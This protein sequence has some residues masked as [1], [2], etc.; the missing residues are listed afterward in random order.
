MASE[1]RKLAN[2]FRRSWVSAEECV[3]FLDGVRAR[4]QNALV[5]G[6]TIG[7][8]DP[9]WRPDQGPMQFADLVTLTRSD[10]EGDEA[11]LQARALGISLSCA[12]LGELLATVFNDDRRAA[13]VF[14][15]TPE[16]V[17]SV[18]H[19]KQAPLVILR[20]A[21]CHPGYLPAPVNEF[22]HVD[23]LIAALGDEQSALRREL[24]RNR[25]ALT[26]MVLARW[27]L[28]RVDDL[29]RFEIGRALIAELRGRGIGVSLEQ[30][31]RIEGRAVDHD[32]PGDMIRR[33]HTAKSALELLGG[34]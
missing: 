5:A 13:S 2:T 17:D 24:S 31:R 19:E 33:L 30:A 9:A 6:R 23:N 29:G 8:S 3:Q 7:P 27:A 14:E 20:N 34:G 1:S 11:G 4:R 22:S 25:F 28:R 18:R 15:V 12:L 16:S 10:V 21:I 32:G 26:G